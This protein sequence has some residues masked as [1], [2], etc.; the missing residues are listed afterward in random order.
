M[1][2]TFKLNL[3]SAT[4]LSMMMLSAPI[5]FAQTEAAP[6]ETQVAAASELV[7]NTIVVTG[8]RSSLLQARDAK[9]SSSVVQDSIVAEDIAKFP[10]LN[11]AESLQRLPGV[12]INR[13][14]GEGRRVSLRG[15]GLFLYPC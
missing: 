8:F 6:E 2:P 14:A 1:S 9:R 4:T 3:A 5:A 7:Q 13:E 11:L 15:L 12:T 10:D